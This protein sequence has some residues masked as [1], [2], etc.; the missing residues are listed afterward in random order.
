[1]KRGSLLVFTCVIFILLIVAVFGFSKISGDVN[2]DSSEEDSNGDNYENVK[3]CLEDLDCQDDNDC[4]INTCRDGF[5]AETNVLLCYQNDGCC[6]SGCTPK[7]D[8][9]C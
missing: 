3:T 4:V 5:C 6:P 9:D 1:M 8:N 2:N 7:N